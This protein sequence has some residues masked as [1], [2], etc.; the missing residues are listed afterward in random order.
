MCVCGGGGGGER[1]HRSPLA[2]H[3]F[4]RQAMLTESI[5]SSAL[6]SVGPDFTLLALTGDVMTRGRAG[7]G[8]AVQITS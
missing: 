5:L 6:V 1:R 7:V 4:L 3:K 8:S 2:S